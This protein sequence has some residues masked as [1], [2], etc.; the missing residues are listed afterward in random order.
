MGLAMMEPG[1]LAQ[2]LERL[3]SGEAN[4]LLLLECDLHRCATPSTAEAIL[5]AAEHVILLD[6][7]HTETAERAH[8][9]LPVPTY[10]ESNGTLVNNECRA[11][12]FYQ[13][14]GK[15]DHVRESWRWLDALR[16]AREPRQDGRETSLASLRSSLVAAFPVF[17]AL[18]EAEAQPGRRQVQGKIPRQPHRY[19]G[20]TAMRANL[21]VHEP[22]PPED[23]DTPLAFSME[24]YS[25][26]PPADLIPRYWSP[27]WNSVQA[28]NKFQAEVGGP[29]RGG[30]PGIRLIEP[31]KSTTWSYYEQ[32]PDAFKPRPDQLL[33]LPRY[34]I[35]GSEPLSAKAP[36]I[37]E[38]SPDPYL[39]LGPAE[40]ESR[41]LEEGSRVRVWDHGR[42]S[43]LALRT[44]DSLPEGVA[45]I[46]FGL[47]ELPYGRPPAWV[48]VEREERA[49][50]DA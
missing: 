46:P 28:L 7:T 5:G 3:E 26:K 43:V 10:A 18:G 37:A 19:S 48:R 42:D 17:A 21:D 29:L 16:T 9:T 22:K 15:G 23:E 32:I 44:V 6:H 45:L 14:F 12:R 24:G 47:S 1:D 49:K 34:H 27:G 39:A 33:A 11:Q 40:A 38:L 31:S 13:V 35:F 41:G 36:G 25:G 8:L 4:T 2:A 50:S 30:D 20:R